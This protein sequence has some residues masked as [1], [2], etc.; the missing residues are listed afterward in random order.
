MTLLLPGA[1]YSIQ[2]YLR[3]RPT[4]LNY[5]HSIISLIRLK[6]NRLQRLCFFRH[7]RFQVFKNLKFGL[8]RLFRFLKPKN[9]GF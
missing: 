9:L 1:D 5:K 3:I 8:L 7:V 2:D 4:L 6:S